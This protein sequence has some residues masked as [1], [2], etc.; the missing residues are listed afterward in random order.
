MFWKN[1]AVV[2]IAAC[3]LAGCATSPTPGN[4]ATQVPLDRI[5]EKSYL[6]PDIYRTELVMVVRDTG[7]MGSGL[8]LIF[9]VDT[10]P[11]AALKPGEK[12]EVY[13]APGKYVFVAEQN[14]NVFDEP[15][16]ESA[17]DIIQGQG[18]K[19]RLR[20]IPEDGPKFERTI[21]P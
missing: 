12:V 6:T 2:G 10:H 1:L 9:K 4:V 14:P 13:L 19:F 21:Q 7:F 17:V 16:G 18:N 5:L 11:V 15:P 3:W 8:Q 20:L